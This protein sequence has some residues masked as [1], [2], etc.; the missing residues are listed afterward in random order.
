M[1][2]TLSIFKIYLDGLPDEMPAHLTDKS[3]HI[4]ADIEKNENL[5][6]EE[7]EDMMIGFGYQTWPWHRA[8]QEYL[9]ATE[10]SMFDHLVVP[11]LQQELRNKYEKFRRYGIPYEAFQS[12][13]C[14]REHFSVEEIPRLVA[15]IMDTK[16]NVEGLTHRQIEGQQKDKFLLRVMALNNILSEIK[17]DLDQMKSMAESETDHTELAHEIRAKVR[18]F[19]QGLCLLAPEPHPED[20][21][22]ALEF[23]I[24]RKIDLN[25]LK[26]IHHP[27]HIDFYSDPIDPWV[28]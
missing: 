27:I 7:L 6:L 17:T 24:G 26:G 4:L 11:K 15:A 20:T 13:A 12:G 18:R 9:R 28:C 14:L 10:H 25:R 16:H 2:S 23:F 19:E 1:Q 8:Y 21:R 22:Q 3:D 5:T